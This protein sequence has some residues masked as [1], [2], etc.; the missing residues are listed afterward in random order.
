MLTCTRLSHI[1]THTLT[2]VSASVIPPWI[3]TLSIHCY[4]I[5]DFLCLL[6]FA[7]PQ[8]PGIAKGNETKEQ[9][10]FPKTR[11][12]SRLHLP[13]AASL[14]WRPEVFRDWDFS[15]FG[16]KLQ[17]YVLPYRTKKKRER[18]K[19]ISARCAYCDLKRSKEV[20]RL[21]PTA[22]LILFWKLETWNI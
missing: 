19:L 2:L 7:T 13:P 20:W 17:G 10:G 3:L 1:Y 14:Q 15:I 9:W 4:K 22:S 18:E 6:F 5:R 16:I 12:Q 8:P 11:A 21:R